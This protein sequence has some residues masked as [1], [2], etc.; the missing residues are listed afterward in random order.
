[1]VQQ[2]GTQGLFK[3]FSVEKRCGNINKGLLE[4]RRIKYFKNI[5][6]ILAVSNITFS[7]ER[8][9]RSR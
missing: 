5:N 6:N 3:E 9:E 7:R 4:A 2:L 8:H 1:M